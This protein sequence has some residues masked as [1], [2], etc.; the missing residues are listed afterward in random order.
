MPDREKSRVD[1]D[2]VP[3][4][5]LWNLYQRA[6]EARRPDAVLHDPKAI[7][8]VDSLDYPFADRFGQGSLGQWQ[9]LRARCFDQEVRCF[10]TEHPDGQVVALGEGLETQFW[11]VDNG[12]VRWLTVDLPETV[13]LRARLLPDDPPR[14]RT[15]ACSALDEEWMRHVDPAEGLLLSAQGLLMYFEPDQV[16]RLI[17]GCAE[18][19]P[20]VTMV[21]DGVPPW[22][23]RRT[24]DGR[25][26]TAQG[27]QAPPMPWAVDGAE[28]ARIRALPNV[29]ELR[30][31]RAPRGRG[32]LYGAVF[33]LLNRFRAVRALGVTGLPIMT[34]RFGR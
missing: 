10:L 26:K 8:L 14:R 32:P 3:E 9:A 1:L 28:K 15:L 34:V 4:T 7:D 17:A 24:L 31:L 20:G 2:G 16:H 6:T 22:F 18:R 29:T 21:F 13:E 25:M 12:R 23:S 27:Y 19:F 30:D 33:P 11:R 5:L